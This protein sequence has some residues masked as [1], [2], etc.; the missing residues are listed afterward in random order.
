MS[1]KGS[2]A[3]PQ[4]GVQPAYMQYQQTQPGYLAQQPPLPQY[5]HPAYQKPQPGYLADQ[6]P[7]NQ[8]GQP[9]PGYVAHEAPQTPYGQFAKPASAAATHA[10]SPFPFMN[11]LA[12]NGLP[13]TQYVEQPGTSVC[14]STGHLVGPWAECISSGVQLEHSRNWQSMPEYAA[15]NGPVGGVLDALNS[16]F[17]SHPQRQRFV[18][19]AERLEE[20]AHAAAERGQP[21]P[22]LGRSDG[23]IQGAQSFQQ[24]QS[25]YVGMSGPL[26]GQ[27]AQQ[28][29]PPMGQPMLAQ[30]Q[31]PY[32]QAAGNP[33][34]SSQHVAQQQQT[35]PTLLGQQQ[36]P[37][38]STGGGK[39]GAVAA[40]VGG[41]AAG[42][43]GGYMLAQ[44]GSEVGSALGDATGW[45]GDRGG[46]ALQWAGG[47]AQDVG[48]FLEGAGEGALG[49]AGEAAHDVGEF[50]DDI[51]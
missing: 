51:F 2:G 45:M 46:D 38:G 1:S 30:Q 35:Y 33:Y 27:H 42:A 3:S 19:A 8:Y 23:Y 41:V 48:G 24:Q 44:H 6:R 12:P 36:Q 18:E 25:P 49:W 21:L 17:A 11:T 5:G 20:A 37:P 9:Q 50:M 26:T 14:D 7:Q 43:L 16:A 15:G 10:K 4:G 47:A 31:L 28:Q 40:G 34:T 32:G 39:F 13:W 29:L 22:G